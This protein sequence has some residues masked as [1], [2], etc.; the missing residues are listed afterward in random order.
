MVRKA[1]VAVSS[2][3]SAKLLRLEKSLY[4]GVPA[5]RLQLSL[6]E[7]EP[8]YLYISR[9]SAQDLHEG[10]FTQIL[11]PTFYGQALLFM[12]KASALDLLSKKRHF[13]STLRQKLARKGFDKEQ[14]DGALEFAI[15]KGYVDDTETAF[16]CL[17]ELKRPQRRS[18]NQCLAALLRKGVSRSI[19]EQALQE[20]FSEE[21]ENAALRYW[22][23][24]E[25]ADTPFQKIA[26]RLLQKGFSFSAI[27]KEATKSRLSS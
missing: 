8:V 24:R 7:Q 25:Q 13:S 22:L 5:A 9:S 17:E 21:D 11:T 23:A 6:D 26:Q 20:G 15:A 18:K 12:A 19:V 2:F 4:A 3:Q 1:L 16:L 27:K 14:V 10:D